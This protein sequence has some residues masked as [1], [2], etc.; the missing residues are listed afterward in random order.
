MNRN[1]ESYVGVL[2]IKGDI[3]NK[4]FI[5]NEIFKYVIPVTDVR[6]CSQTAF[7][8]YNAC[9]RSEEI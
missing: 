4:I 8:Q 1:R 2:E 9:L 3:N 7:H 6:Y 5:R